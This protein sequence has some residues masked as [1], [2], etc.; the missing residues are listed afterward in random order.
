MIS[1]YDNV[2]GDEQEIE[3]EY[4]D[5]ISPDGFWRMVKEKQEEKL[6]HAE[7]VNKKYPNRE[8]IDFI[9]DGYSFSDCEFS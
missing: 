6:N 4:G 5:K 7:Y 1:Q 8:S 2:F 9:I 3:N